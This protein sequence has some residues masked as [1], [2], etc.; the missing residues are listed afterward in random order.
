[1][2]Y[3]RVGY[4]LARHFHCHDNFPSAGVKTVQI[5]RSQQST[6][7]VTID[8]H[9]TLSIRWNHGNFMVETQCD[10]EIQGTYIAHEA[11]EDRK[12]GRVS[13]CPIFKMSQLVE[14]REPKLFSNG[15]PVVVSSTLM[16]R[17][18]R[19]PSDPP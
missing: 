16:K 3:G 13:L 7:R 14:M 10:L 11:A 9:E 8:V 15:S 2:I 19:Q 12:V 4:S 18:D 1:M 6:A 17:Q 5:L